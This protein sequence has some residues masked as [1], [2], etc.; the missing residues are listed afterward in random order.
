LFVRSSPPTQNNKKT[1]SSSLH[2]SLD[3]FL[4]YRIL[5]IVQPKK[6]KKNSKKMTTLKEKAV[7]FFGIVYFFVC[8]L[9]HQ[10]ILH[11]RIA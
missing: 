4:M 3:F 8:N 2:T 5:K 6:K 1:I 9:I 10:R 11:T 7:R